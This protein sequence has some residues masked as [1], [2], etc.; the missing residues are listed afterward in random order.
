[1]DIIEWCQFKHLNVAVDTYIQIYT[2]W[3]LL[4]CIW[5]W[6]I[7][8]FEWDSPITSRYVPCILYRLLSRPT[9]AL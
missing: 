8:C 7:A 1:M 5:Y 6:R 3:V 9:N 4:S 2:C